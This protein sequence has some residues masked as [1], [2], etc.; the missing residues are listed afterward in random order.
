MKVYV[1]I[2]DWAYDYDS[3]N[4]VEV[5]NTRQKALDSL[6]EKRK[7]ARID[8]DL[9]GKTD[10]EIEGIIEEQDESS[11]TVYEDGYYSKNHISIR[12]EEK[13]IK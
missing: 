1:V 13:E 3:G 4:N 12:I 11:Y 5:Y 7:S 6:Q 10:E 2:E 9:E 8:F